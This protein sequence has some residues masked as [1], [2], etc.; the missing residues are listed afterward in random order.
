M[1]EKHLR[2]LSKS[3]VN[4]KMQIKTT[5]R[6]H[7]TTIRMAKKI[8]QAK[9]RASKDVKQGSAP[10]LLVAVRTCTTTLETNLELCLKIGHSS[11]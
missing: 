9:T 11:T 6:F 8:I 3:L 5:L 1:A 7:L 10:A 4:R 2:K